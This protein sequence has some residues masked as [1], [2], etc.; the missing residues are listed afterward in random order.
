M[1]TVLVIDSVGFSIST[2]I[3]TMKAPSLIS[4]NNGL[5]A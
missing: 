2:G 1:H 4:Y 5:D 3:Y